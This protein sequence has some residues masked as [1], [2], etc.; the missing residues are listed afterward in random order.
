[1][2]EVGEKSPSKNKN[3]KLNQSSTLLFLFEKPFERKPFLVKNMKKLNR[4]EK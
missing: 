4:F 3:S 2:S 1:M